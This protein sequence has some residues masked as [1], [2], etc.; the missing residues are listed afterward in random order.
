MLFRSHCINLARSMNLCSS[1]LFEITGVSLSHEH[2]QSETQSV[3]HTDFIMDE[4]SIYIDDDD[5]S[6][7]CMITEH[8]QSTMLFCPL[9]L[10]ERKEL[11][12]LVNITI[13]SQIECGN[14]IT[15]VDMREPCR[16][17]PIEGD[18]NCFF[19]SVA[20][21]L[22]GRE[23]DHRKIRLAVVKHMRAK[24]EIYQPFLRAG[25]ESVEQYITQSRMWYVRTW[26]TELEILASSDLL[27]HDICIFS[28]NRWVTYSR[29]QICNEHV[30]TSTCVYLYHK[31]ENHYD[32]SSV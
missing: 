9:T 8:E 23:N 22:S 6:D 7:D 32:V 25:Y 26:A 29:S 3:T 12:N 31:D 19:R 16:T 4:E 13:L 21:V 20:Y 2:E 15:G 18:G 10:E 17:I 14:P 27:G 28:D 24:S 1:T 5:T 11:C 30:P